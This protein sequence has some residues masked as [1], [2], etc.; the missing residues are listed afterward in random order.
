GRVRAAGLPIAAL[1]TGVALVPGSVEALGGGPELDNEVAGQ[2]LRLGLA[3]LLAPELDQG[4]FVIAHD[5]SGVR[6]TDEGT[7]IFVGLCPHGRFHSFAPD[8][9]IEQKNT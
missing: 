4:R 7:T 8:C 9:K 5:D 2:V 6:A 3:T 1:P